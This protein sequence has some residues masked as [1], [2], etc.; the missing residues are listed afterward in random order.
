MHLM[1]FSESPPIYASLCMTISGGRTKQ[2]DIFCTSLALRVIFSVSLLWNLF[3]SFMETFNCSYCKTIFFYV[4]IDYSNLIIKTL[5]MAPFN[6]VQS[7]FK[8]FDML[9]SNMELFLEHGTSLTR[10]CSCFDLKLGLFVKKSDILS[11]V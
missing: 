5:K 11:S 4:S 7:H 1:L 6:F 3:S 9:I 8:G 10:C 2:L